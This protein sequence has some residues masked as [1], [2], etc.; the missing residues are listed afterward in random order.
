MSRKNKNISLTKY[1][2]DDG[3]LSMDGLLLARNGTEPV[4]AFIG[5]KVMDVWVNLS[6]T[7]RTAE[8]VPRLVQCAWQAQPRGD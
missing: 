8:P 1:G 6:S 3:P 5:R 2:I 4:E 7:G